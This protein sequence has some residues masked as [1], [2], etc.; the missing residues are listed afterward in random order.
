MPNRGRWV[1]LDDERREPVG[2][3]RVRTS[4]ECIESLAN[5]GVDIVSLDHDLAVEHYE[6][7]A[8]GRKCT[9]YDVAL[10]LECQAIM[11]EWALVPKDLRCHSL[12]PA[13]RARIL[14]A[15]ASIERRR[16][17]TATVVTVAGEEG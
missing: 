4:V 3:E 9:G 12:N 14:A 5:G 11:G 13:G 16:A 6:N 8:A 10:W 1:W 2:W 7:T 15:F 17:A